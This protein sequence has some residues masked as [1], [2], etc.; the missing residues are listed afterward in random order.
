MRH[1][2]YLTVLIQ[3]SWLFCRTKGLRSRETVTG[4]WNYFKTTLQKQHTS[5]VIHITTR[6]DQLF[7]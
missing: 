3:E 4:N 6:C 1:L 5:G 7:H 2:Q